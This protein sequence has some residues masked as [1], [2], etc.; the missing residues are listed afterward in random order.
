MHSIDIDPTIYLRLEK[1]DLNISR[2]S[3]NS[4]LDILGK[5]RRVK[6]IVQGYQLREPSVP[7][8]DHFGVQ[9][10]DMGSK[11]T[12]LWNDSR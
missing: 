10:D 3:R 7:Y 6:E 2:T 5:G 12:Y 11:N 1:K 4:L 8:G 9:K